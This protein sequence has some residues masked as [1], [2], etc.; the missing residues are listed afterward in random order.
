[1]TQLEIAKKIG[2][3][4]GWYWKIYNGYAYPGKQS[5]KKLEAV[6]GKAQAWWKKAGQSQIQR[7]LDAIE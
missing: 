6:T 2:I 1:M 4:Q 5:A 3:S 7:T